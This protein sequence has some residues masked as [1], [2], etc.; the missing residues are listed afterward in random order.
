VTTDPLF[1]WDQLKNLENILKHRVSFED[2]Q[3]AFLDPLRVIIEDVNHSQHEP[4]WFCIGKA[5]DKSGVITVRFTY[6]REHIRILGAGY[7]RRGKRI[8]E[9][10]NKVHK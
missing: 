1:E 7:W 4:R 6:R 8:Y 5:K 3:I 2:A 9:E 10:K